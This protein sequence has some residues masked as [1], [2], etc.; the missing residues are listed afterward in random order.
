VKDKKTILFPEYFP[1]LAG[2]QAVMLSV[3]KSLMKTYNIRAVVFNR[4]KIEDELKK[5]GIPCDFMQAPKNAR[6][7]YFWKSVP[8][9]FRLKKYLIENNISLVYSNGYFTAKLCGPAA[10]AAGVP[11]IWH[12]HQIIT[13]PKNSYLA[14]DVRKYSAYAEKIICVSRASADSMADIGVDPS[15][16]IVIHNGIMPRAARHGTRARVRKKLGLEGCFC[17]GTVGYFMKNKG[18]EFLI[19]A[20][21]TACSGNKKIKF[22]ITG[23]AEPGMEK[24]GEYLRQKAALLA[25]SVI[26]TGKKDRYEVLPAFDCFVLPSIEEPF[27]LSVLEAM[28]MR[29]PVI[30][31]RSG[32]TPEIV[33]H[34]KNGLLASDISAAALAAE[35][36]KAASGGAFLRKAGANAFLTVRRD[37]SLDAQMKA[38][39]AV[40]AGALK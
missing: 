29:L 18:L 7:R 34:E 9:F 21:K 31:F 1:F 40:V 28:S 12:K 36:M 10:K 22:V 32:G 37:F 11:M 38:V 5:L 33:R 23:D 19:D 35:I 2:G 15:K 16:L 25:G 14:R 39:S 17:A 8:L 30:A 3:I 13:G 27:A 4:G 6:Q 20:A 26:F 24:Y